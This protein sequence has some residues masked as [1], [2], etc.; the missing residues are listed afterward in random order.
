MTLV[1]LYQPSDVQVGNAIAVGQKERV[2][3]YVLL[4]PFRAPTGHCGQAGVSQG[5]L[6]ILFAV[7]VVELDL[8]LAPEAD[9]EVVV[10]CLVV[11]EVLFDHVAAISQA[12]DKLA[13]ATVGIEL[14]DVP[15]DGSTA[16]FDHRFRPEFSFLAQAGTESS[17]QHNYFH[18]ILLADASVSIP[19]QGSR[20]TAPRIIDRCASELPKT[21]ARLGFA[22]SSLISFSYDYNRKRFP[23]G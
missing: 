21:T 14:H 5:D 6:E 20:Q 13:E 16:N 8:R 2:V 15:Q 3:I 22:T 23:Y 10:H 9:G 4:D 1:E 19:G 7:Y 11:Q 18:E 12:Q 17:A